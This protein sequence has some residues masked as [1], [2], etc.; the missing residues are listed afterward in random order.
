[1]VVADTEE[2]DVQQVME[3]IREAIRRRRSAEATTER[4]SASDNGSGILDVGHLQAVGDLSSVA[5]P[6][7]RRVL[8]PVMVAIKKTLLKLL[9]PMLEQQA[10]YNAAATRALADTDNRMRAMEW[11]Q[12][13][14]L[15]RSEEQLGASIAEVSA[16]LEEEV[17]RLQGDLFSR[18]IEDVVARQAALRQE[19]LAEVAA[20][21]EELAT[22]SRAMDSA[23]DAAMDSARRVDARL[24]ERL[25]ASER[26]WRR[27]LHVLEGDA[28]PAAGSDA[29]P[30]AH[31]PALPAAGLEPEFDYAGFEDRFR[32]AETD[33][34]ERQ[35]IYVPLF[36]GASRVVDL[37]SGRGEFLELLREHGIPGQGVDLD[38]DMTLLCRDK[39]LNVVRE[40]AFSYLAA[41]ADDSVGGIFSAQFIEHLPPRRIVELV[42]LCYRKLAH[43]GV[44]VLETP[45]PTCLTVFADSFYR[46]LSHVQPIHPETMKFLL[47]ATG[48]QGVEIKPL[49]PVDPARRVPPLLSDEPAVAAFNQGIDR[50]NALLFGFQ[51]Y[52]IVGWRRVG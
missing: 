2:V 16:R 21:R 34:K 39:G 12:A 38:L 35:R 25:S 20:L 13:Q 32:G 22:R 8:G 19:V 15:A 29:K 40:D 50:L 43:D 18:I 23:M 1:M 30:P 48:F 46:D 28:A 42:K 37:G 5:V 14:A 4:P 3:R 9:T 41:C 10:A 45:N 52:G 51:D 47:E 36:E 44:L 17:G 7:H 11:R 31:R 49:A 33:I 24:T 6:S 27:V 26:R